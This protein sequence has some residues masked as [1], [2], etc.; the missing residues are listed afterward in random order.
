MW[1]PPLVSKYLFIFFHPISVFFFLTGKCFNINTGVRFLFSLSITGA[2]FATSRLYEAKQHTKELLS[3]LLVREYHKFYSKGV[4]QTG[5]AQTD[6][7]LWFRPR[8]QVGFINRAED[9]FS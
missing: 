8:N 7:Q 2:I 1:D 3:K 9:F 6:K 5:I 4:P